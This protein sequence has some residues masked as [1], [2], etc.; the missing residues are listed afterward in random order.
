MK[1]LETQ[2]HESVDWDYAQTLPEKHTTL[3]KFS[4]KGS[5]FHQPLLEFNGACAGCTETA[6]MKILTQSSGRA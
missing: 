6:Y 1:P 5:Q 3:D 2:R 4:V